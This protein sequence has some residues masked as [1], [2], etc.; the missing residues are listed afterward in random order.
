MALRIDHKH[1]FLIF[2][3]VEMLSITKSGIKSQLIWEEN[4]Y[5]L[6]TRYAKNKMNK[7]SYAM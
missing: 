4:I 6:D 1:I 3:V 2:I 7:C 5:K